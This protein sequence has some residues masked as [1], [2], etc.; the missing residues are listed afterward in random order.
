[1]TI[2]IRES[3]DLWRTLVKGAD[4]S[5]LVPALEFE[6]GASQKRQIDAVFNHVTTA[7]AIHTSLALRLPCSFCLALFCGAVVVLH[8]PLVLRI[9]TSTYAGANRGNMC[10]QR[11]IGRLHHHVRT[12][13]AVKSCHGWWPALHPT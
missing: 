3:K 5:I 13:A 9:C 7:Y 4:A 11:I 12:R 10:S 6:I 1:M 2:P 8:S